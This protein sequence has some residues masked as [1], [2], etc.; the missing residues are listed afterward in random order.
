MDYFAF[1]FDGVVCNSAK[2][3]GLTAWRAANAMWP[4]LVSSEPSTEF[5]ARFPILRP[6]VETGYDNLPLVRLMVDGYSDDTILTQF[7]S[8]TAELIEAENLNRPELRSRFGAARD[9]W[10][11][12]DIESW[13]AAQNFYPGVVEA[14]NALDAP[15]CIITT[16]EARFTKVL[17][18]RASLAVEPDRVYALESFEGAGKRSV[19]AALAREYPDDDCHFFEDRFVTL[20]GI[21]DLERTHHYLVDWGYNTPA[22]RERAASDDDIK[23]L[24]MDAFTRLLAQAG[25]T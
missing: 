17:I 12:S 19:L 15:A 20:D 2:E 24:D 7:Q 1:D 13:L 11:K 6:V 9:A 22:E 4:E 21:R 23:L 8:L 10:I 14:I 18:E 16:K 3:T 25:R 5:V